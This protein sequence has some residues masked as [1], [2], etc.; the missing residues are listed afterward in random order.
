MNWSFRFN[1]IASTKFWS[2]C[3][4]DLGDGEGVIVSCNMQITRLNKFVSVSKQHFG[5]MNEKTLVRL[6]HH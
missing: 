4:L 6:I 5:L 3:K 1:L 2:L